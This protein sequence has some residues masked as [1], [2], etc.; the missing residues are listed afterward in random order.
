MIALAGLG[1][2]F[3]TTK[4]LD[5]ITFSVRPGEIF[6]LLGPNGAGKSTLINILITMLRRKEGSVLVD[7]FDPDEDPDL[8]R[9]RLGVIFQDSTLDERLTLRENLR[10]HSMLFGMSRTDTDLRVGES[11]ADVGLTD[12]ADE[13]VMRLSGGQKR[14]LEIARA[15]IHRP[16][17]LVIDEPTTGLDSRARKEI[18]DRIKALNRDH[19]ATVFLT[20]HYLEE[21]E[22]CDR[23]A[24]LDRGRIVATG[25]P[26]EVRASGGYDRV[27]IKT[28]RFAEVGAAAEMMFGARVAPTDAADSI[29]LFVADGSA[30]IAGLYARFGASI[31]VTEFRKPTLD[32]AFIALTGNL[33]D[34]PDSGAALHMRN[35][36]RERR[37]V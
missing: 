1:H 8:V 10:F 16:K 2:S 28:R 34:D 14:R 23:I 13:P 27:R 11:L 4:V 31:S 3:G 32:D 36:V 17:L 37:L 12:R 9:A 24:I 30:L 5:G 25:S 20:T 35:L 22:V 19:G 7:G 15:V 18:W 21:A 29:E 26:D 33:P 6:G